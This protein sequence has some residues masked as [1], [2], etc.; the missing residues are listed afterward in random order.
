VTLPSLNPIRNMLQCQRFLCNLG[1]CIGYCVRRFRHVLI[2]IWVLL[3]PNL[4][5]V[6]TSRETSADHTAY[7][8]HMYEDKHSKETQ[9]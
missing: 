9:L 6:G 8:T 3:T 2:P 5:E 1:V 7:G 4:Q